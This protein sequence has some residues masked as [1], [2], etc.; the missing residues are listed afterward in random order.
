MTEVDVFVTDDA[1]NT[2]ED[3]TLAKLDALIDAIKLTPPCDARRAL[4]LELASLVT[5]D[6]RAADF[7][8]RHGGRDVLLK[9]LHGAMRVGDEELMDAVG[10]AV[11]SRSRCDSS[12]DSVELLAVGGSQVGAASQRPPGVEVVR[13][14]HARVDVHVHESSWTDAGLAWRIWGASR[15]LAHALDAAA[16]AETT[17]TAIRAAGEEA[18][19]SKKANETAGSKGDENNASLA[20]TQKDTNTP[21][22]IRVRGSRVLELGAG[23]GLGGLAA[24]AL[25]AKEVT[26]TE[27]APGSLA[28]IRKSAKDNNLKSDENKNENNTGVAARVA[29]LDWRDDEAALDSMADRTYVLDIDAEVTSVT[30]TSP[31]KRNQTTEQNPTEPKPYQN[32]VHKRDVAAP[33]FMANLPRLSKTET[34]DL[35]IGSDLL[36]DETHAA[37]LAASIAL[38]LERSNAARAHVVLAVRNGKLITKLALDA[39]DR[40]LRVK[41]ACLQPFCETVSQDFATQQGGHITRQETDPEAA[42]HW[43]FQGG[44]IFATGGEAGSVA[45]LDEKRFRFL[46]GDGEK[47]PVDSDLK[48]QLEGLIVGL[49]GRVAMVSFRWPDETC[50]GGRSYSELL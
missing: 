45:E 20:S 10:A 16:H 40:G 39:Y 1:E 7:A 28:A 44:A 19:S 34:F 17:E 12:S 14:R 48:K 4:L 27:G 35:V 42:E 2:R 23:C 47:V 29:F 8:E 31:S 3:E 22:V 18:S 21:V 36:Y 49:Q 13:L 43:R 9:S 24:A 38:R 50:A 5:A 6:A 33:D 46:D 32:W 15:I 41:I 37:P 26:I 11:A 30:S 25:G